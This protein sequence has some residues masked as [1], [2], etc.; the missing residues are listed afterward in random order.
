MTR[1]RSNQLIGVAVQR[2]PAVVDVERDRRG[3]AR[4]GA[5]AGNLADVDTADPHGRAR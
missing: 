5:D 1:R 2:Q 3:R 4:P